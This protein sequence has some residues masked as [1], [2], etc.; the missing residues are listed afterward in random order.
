MPP[1]FSIP[2]TVSKG[3][4]IAGFVGVAA[5]SVGMIVLRVQNG[6]PLRFKVLPDGSLALMTRAEAIERRRSQ[7]QRRSNENPDAQV[8]IDMVAMYDKMLAAELEKTPPQIPITDDE[9]A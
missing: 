5:I 2:A 9:L 3:L 4:V 1:A 8:F 7:A 6:A